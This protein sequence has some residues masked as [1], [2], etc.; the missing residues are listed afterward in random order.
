MG[1][2]F[3]S[4]TGSAEPIFPDLKDQ[5]LVSFQSCEETVLECVCL[6]VRKCK[7]CVYL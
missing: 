1:G 5:G 6:A 4:A 7:V 2:I 3:S